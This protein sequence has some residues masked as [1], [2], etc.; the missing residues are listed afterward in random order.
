MPVR[1][2]RW[3]SEDRTERPVGAQIML[4]MWCRYGSSGLFPRWVLQLLYTDLLDWGNWLFEVC[5]RTSPPSLLPLA[6]L[7]RE[8]SS[9]P[10]AS[11]VPS[12]CAHARVILSKS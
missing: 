2:G 11:L 8:T 6:L 5:T 3:L 12:V 9:V 7:A 4:L 10:N 1:A